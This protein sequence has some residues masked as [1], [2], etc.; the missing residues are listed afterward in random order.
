MR[1]IN[2]FG[3]IAMQKPAFAK[4]VDELEKRNQR[5]RRRRALKKRRK[6]NDSS[7]NNQ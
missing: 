6:Q 4:L 2:N 3:D 7:E 5:T 1:S